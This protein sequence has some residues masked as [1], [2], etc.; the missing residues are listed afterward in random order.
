MHS[1]VGLSA[2]RSEISLEPAEI[3]LGR[4]LKVK[5][6]SFTSQGHALLEKT[7]SGQGALKTGP[8]FGDPDFHSLY[9][10]PDLAVDENRCFRYHL[11]LPEDKEKADK[12]I[13]LLHGFNERS[14]SKYLPWAAQLVKRTGHGV[15]LFPLAFH[16]NRAPKLWNNA[17]AMRKVSSER[18][19]LYPDLLQSTLSNAAISIRLH[20]NPARFFWSGLVSYYDILDFVRTI[21]DSRHPGI[22]PM[23]PV[24]FFAYSIGTLLSEIVLFTDEDGLFSD[25]KLAAFCG[26][27][28]F[29]RLSPVTKF[30]LDSE[31]DVQLYSFLVEHLDSHR[32][33]DPELDRYLSDSMPVGRNFRCLLNYRLDRLYREARF[34]A[35][36][37]RILA[38]AL[39]QDE[40][41]PPY[42]IIGTF[43]GSR[44]DIGIRVEVIDLPYRYRHEDPF[45]PAGPGKTEADEQM[46]RVFKLAADFLA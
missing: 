5:N 32:R 13:F 42:E 15:L 45:P 23:A 41:V 11:M 43:Q 6:Y 14:W 19:S 39:A 34:K 27:P 4:G 33:A 1:T 3:S 38:L 20:A 22:D 36:A 10:L 17:R 29:N 12:L 8:T 28:V 44:R 24:S 26:G 46:D 9:H 37:D 40:V 31:A 25:S 21:R 35:L 16:M 18:Q 2:L 30:I 7:G